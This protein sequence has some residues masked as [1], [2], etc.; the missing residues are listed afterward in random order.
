VA[1]RVADGIGY[2][3]GLGPKSAP[4]FAGVSPERFG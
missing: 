4:A 1:K 3:L 2:C